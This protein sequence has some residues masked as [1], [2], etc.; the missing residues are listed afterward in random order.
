M[1]LYH[2]E[3]IEVERVNGKLSIFLGKQG[4]ATDFGHL[5]LTAVNGFFVL[6][7]LFTFAEVFGPESFVAWQFVDGELTD[8]QL[9]VYL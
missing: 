2:D 1:A 3:H 5:V 9:G 4:S 6:F 7:D 8:W